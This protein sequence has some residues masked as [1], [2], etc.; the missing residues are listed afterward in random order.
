N[1]YA[2]HRTSPS[3]QSPRSYRRNVV[4]GESITA[5]IVVLH[6]ALWIDLLF[7]GSGFTRERLDWLL[8][9]L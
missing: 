5:F 1:R 8:R 4:Q 6:Q 3:E 9:L 7:I 2:F